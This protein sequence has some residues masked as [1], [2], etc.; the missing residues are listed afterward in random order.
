MSRRIVSQTDDFTIGYPSLGFPIVKFLE[1]DE[2]I[3]GVELKE[4]DK[5]PRYPSE[6]DLESIH[7]ITIHKKRY[8]SVHQDYTDEQLEPT[9]NN[10]YTIETKLDGNFTHTVLLYNSRV[11]SKY[12]EDATYLDFLGL[13]KYDPAL[14]KKDVKGLAEIDPSVYEMAK[15]REDLKTINTPIAEGKDIPAREKAA[16]DAAKSSEG[17]AISVEESVE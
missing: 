13:P 14:H 3:N 1:E 9:E 4:G 7:L 10:D 17:D 16:E 11:A 5:D 12:K 8:D 15:S 6:A 2:T